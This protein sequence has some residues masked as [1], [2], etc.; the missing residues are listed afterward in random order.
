L[1]SNGCTLYIT[2][3]PEDGSNE[4]YVS[5]GIIFQTFAKKSTS[6]QNSSTT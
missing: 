2:D 6:R 3:K 5:A 1:H 4:E